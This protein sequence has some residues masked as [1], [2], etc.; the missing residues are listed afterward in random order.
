M[1]TASDRE[2]ERSVNQPPEATASDREAERI[3]NQ[4][5]HPTASVLDHV[6]VCARDLLP[7]TAAYEELG[8]T[9]TPIAQQSGRRTPDSAVEPFGTGNRCAFLRHGYVELLAILDPTLFANQVDRFIA[10]YEGLHICALGCVDAEANLAR[11]QAAGIPIPGIAWLERKVE[12]SD[13][14]LARFARLPFPDA[15]EGRIQIIQH[16][17]PELVWQDR[18]MTHANHA[19]ALV[20][21]V[22]VSANPA[23][24]AARLSRLTG[25]PFTP[26]P[27][28]GF[29]I[30]LPGA[31]R[32]AGPRSPRMETTVRVLDAEAIPRVFPGVTPPTLPFM[33][34]MVVRT[35]DANAAVRAMGLPLVD[36]P[37]GLMVPPAL[38][39]GAALIFAP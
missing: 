9:L 31:E 22:M 19:D 25:L 1:S 15:P 34:G 18:W 8:F 4:P 33:A 37:D 27:A 14:R 13:P 16:M 7:L 10:R 21:L 38:A 5:L 11:M 35:D 23:E 3:V 2:A 26:D 28:G 20:S 36:A 29:R 39:G 32:G 17:T 6:G 30:T 24:T 12:A